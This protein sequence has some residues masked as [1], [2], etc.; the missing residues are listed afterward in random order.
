MRDKTVI[1][2][3][4]TSS[5]RTEFQQ[6]NSPLQHAMLHCCV[7]VSVYLRSAVLFFF[8]PFYLPPPAD[9]LCRSKVKWL[10]RE[11]TTTE[12]LG[13]ICHENLCGGQ[14]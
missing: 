13:Y 14:L 4:A 3:Q 11:K 8:R 7:Y 5:I 10:G 1:I 2:T 6:M 9:V 12:H